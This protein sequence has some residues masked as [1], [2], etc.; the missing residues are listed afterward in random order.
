MP[1]PGLDLRRKPFVLPPPPEEPLDFLLDHRPK[2]LPV[3]FP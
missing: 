2:E 3:D 1:Q